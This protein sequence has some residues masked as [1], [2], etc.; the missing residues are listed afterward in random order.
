[1]PKGGK[2]KQ[3]KPKK[4]VIPGW[5]PCESKWDKEFPKGYGE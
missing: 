3:K 5:E 2:S 1:M 4:V